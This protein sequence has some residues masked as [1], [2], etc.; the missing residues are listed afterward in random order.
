MLNR[1]SKWNGV[2]VTNRVVVTT[3][4]SH[5]TLEYNQLRYP[6]LCVFVPSHPSFTTVKD[7]GNFQRDKRLTDSQANWA[8]IYMYRSSISKWYLFVCVTLQGGYKGQSRFE[9]GWRKAQRSSAVTP[10]NDLTDSSSRLNVI[11]RMRIDSISVWSCSSLLH[12]T[13]WFLRFN[14]P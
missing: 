9:S 10:N 5:L 2:R 3:F 6:S 4:Y 11:P 14:F 13:L 12:F 8:D 7:T 1:N